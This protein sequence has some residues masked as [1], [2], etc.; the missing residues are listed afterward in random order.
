MCATTLHRIKI[1]SILLVILLL[2]SNMHLLASLDA[3]NIIIDDIVTEPSVIHRGDYF[4][5]NATVKNIS[6]DTIDILNIGCKGPIDVT[7]DKNVEVKPVASGICFN[8]QPILT[9]KPAESLVLSAPDFAEDY[10]ASVDGI[11]EA[12]MQLQYIVRIDNE[13][14]PSLINGT[15]SNYTWI[16]SQPFNFTILPQLVPNYD[17][18]SIN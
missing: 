18:S 14:A 3:P 8:Q 6:N 17:N 9:L 10:K 11:V 5:L 2:G 16:F 15:E 12:T 13:N 4:I 7:F 1:V